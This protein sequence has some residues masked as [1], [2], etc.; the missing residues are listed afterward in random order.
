[1]SVDLSDFGGDND[2]AARD[3]G[4]NVGSCIDSAAANRIW[5]ACYTVA[6]GAP[7]STNETIDILATDNAGNTQAGTDADGYDVDG[8]SPTVDLDGHGTFTY[9]EGVDITF[10]PTYRQGFIYEWVFDD[11]AVANGQGGANSNPVHSYDDQGVYTVEVTVTDNHGNTHTDGDG[12]ADFDS[13]AFTITNQNPGPNPQTVTDFGDDGLPGGADG[14]AD[15]L[16]ADG[17]AIEEVNPVA[18]FTVRN[19]TDPSPVDV[20]TLDYIWDWGDGESFAFGAGGGADAEYTG[21]D[22]GDCTGYANCRAIVG[23][24][25]YASCKLAVDHNFFQGRQ[26]IPYVV[27]LTATDKDGGTAEAEYLLQVTD[28]V[29]VPESEAVTAAMDEADADNPVEIRVWIGGDDGPTENIAYTFTVDWKDGA[30]EQVGPLFWDGVNDVEANLTHVYDDD[31]SQ[32]ESFPVTVSVVTHTGVSNTAADL[33]LTVHNLVPEAVGR[34]APDQTP[35][36]GEPVSFEAEGFDDDSSDPSPFDTL[37]YAWDFATPGDCGALGAGQLCAG[38]D[39]DGS[40]STVSYT[41]NDNATYQVCVRATDDDGGQDDDCFDV[42]VDNV[43]PIT[44]P[45]VDKQDAIEGIAFDLTASALDVAEDEV[46]DYVWLLTDCDLIDQVGATATFVCRDDGL[47]IGWVS[48]NDGEDSDPDDEV[49]DGLGPPAEFN[50]FVSNVRPN[51]KACVAVD[52]GQAPN[53]GQLNFDNFPPANCAEVAEVTVDEAADVVF[54]AAGV[55][56]GV[57]GDFRTATL[58]DVDPNE[59][60]Y[61]WNMG[62]GAQPKT[63]QVITHTFNRVQDRYV[64]ELTTQD[65]DGGRAV[66]AVVVNVRNVAPEADSVEAITDAQ[67]RVEGSPVWFRGA[68]SDTPDDKLTYIW[69]AWPFL[70][71]RNCA[72]VQGQ[73]LAQQD[74]QDLTEVAFTFTDNGEY[75][76]C[77]S[78]RDSA[79]EDSTPAELRITVLN[80]AP[81]ADA[82][83]ERVVAEGEAITLVGTATDPGASEDLEYHWSFGDCLEEQSFDGAGSSSAGTASRS[84][85]RPTS[86]TSASRRTAPASAVSSSANAACRTMVSCIPGAAAAAWTRWYITPCFRLR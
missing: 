49:D 54:A 67:D 1:M 28:V 20:R 25:D 17:L 51:A 12:D 21:V 50:V 79:Q 59:L 76:A 38:F 15:T 83:D 2:E 10:A 46:A 31:P 5:T 16:I 47:H 70:Q 11:G 62:D 65:K 85:C 26:V 32:G 82:G 61:T 40:G 22:V 35:V 9:G 34:E 36:E 13:H 64:V 6:E 74:G 23:C 33:D 56:R 8:V 58:D 37:T 72:N 75:L 43:A 57:V 52:A 30:V 4:A 19:T 68:G 55:D 45:P 80:V 27:T 44:V 41:Y 66:V 78:I 71:G 77:L 53:E 29:P 39:A 24:D 18:T 14:D 84:A 42:T 48:A 81:T 86:A 63:G 7:E 3:N 73:P 69:T 60:L